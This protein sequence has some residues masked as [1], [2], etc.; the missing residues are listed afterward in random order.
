MSALWTSH[1]AAA[2]TGGKIT[3]PWTVSGL[4]IDTRTICEG[5][6]FVPLKDVRD[7]HDFIPMALEKGA[8][9]VISERAIADVPALRVND[10]IL[11]LRDLARASRERC[12]AKRIA[13]T[14]SV[15]K[16]SVKEMLGAALAPSGPTHKSIKS[17]NNHWGVPLMMAAMP[18]DTQYAVLEAGMNHAGEL[19]DLSGLIAPDIAII[20]KIAPAHLEFF[21]S[22][23]HIAAAKA[24]IFDGMAKGGVAI[25]NADDSYFDYLSSEAKA[26]G[27]TVVGVHAAD[28]KGGLK[29]SGA[30]NRMNAALVM[31]AVK[32]ASGDRKQARAVLSKLTPPAGR[33]ERFTANLAGHKFTVIDE[34]YNANPVSV[35]AAI[36]AVSGQ[37]RKIAVIGD[38]LEL[39]TQSVQ[40]HAGLAKA[41][42]DAGFSQVI[43]VGQHSQ[44]LADA[45]PEKYHATHLAD[46]SGVITALKSIIKDNDSV[47]LKASNSVGLGSVIKE[48]RGK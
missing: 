21:E 22:V 34:S 37:G 44:A 8:A 41:L 38:M 2:A 24:E 26:K 20:T 28:F 40:L 17:Y 15:G 33:G 13:V 12:L 11:A 47:L 43:T 6:L 5:D 25:L 4:S 16:T 42:I 29:L 19:S 36:S 14:G 32:A 9:A 35:A 46:K 18:R 1:E 45:L 30:H 23:D 7:G 48:L 27:L 3:G 39:G 31:A 10:A